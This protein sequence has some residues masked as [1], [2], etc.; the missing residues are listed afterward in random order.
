MKLGLLLPFS[1]PYKALGRRALFRGADGQRSAAGQPFDLV[2][3][4]TGMDFGELPINTDAVGSI[5]EHPGSGLVRVVQERAA[6]S[7]RMSKRLL[8]RSLAVRVWLLPWSL[9]RPAFP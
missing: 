8:V 4:D 5:S 2:I 3:A 7:N 1:G 6:W 9:R